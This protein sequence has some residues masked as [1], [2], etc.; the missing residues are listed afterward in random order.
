MP[1]KAGDNPP[2]HSRFSLPSANASGLFLHACVDLSLFYPGQKHKSHC[3]TAIKIVN[4]IITF[5]TPGGERYQ[6]AT[7]DRKDKTF[8]LS[9]ICLANNGIEIYSLIKN[10]LSSDKLAFAA[11]IIPWEMRH[12]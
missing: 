2:L 8:L 10:A 7:T 6:L 3:G 1:R 4:L 9:I 12:G 11:Q 5:G